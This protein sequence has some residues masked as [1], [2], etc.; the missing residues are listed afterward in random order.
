MDIS[1]SIT[2][3]ISILAFILSLVATVITSLREK[4]ENKRTMRMELTEVLNKIID[5]T[6]E[7]VSMKEELKNKPDHF[8]NLSSHLNQK[9][10]TLLHQAIFLTDK[11]PNLVLPMNYN[12]IAISA[13]NANDI[14]L[15][16]KYF[17]K[18]IK[19]TKQARYKKIALRSYAEFLFNVRRLEEGRK[20][21]QEA[22]SCSQGSDDSERAFKGENY[23][24]WGINELNIAHSASRAKDLFESAANEFKGIS[25]S[26]MRKQYENALEKIIKELG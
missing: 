10:A 4:S 22:I 19:V 12:T 24:R 1:N 23:Q 11:I 15:S 21:Y 16:K 25:N 3:Y 8:Q 9:N 6:I 13:F 17:E 14:E 18:D 7:N 2:F 5:L 26:F 20:T